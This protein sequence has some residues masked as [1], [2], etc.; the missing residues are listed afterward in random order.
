TAKPL[1]FMSGH[2][3]DIRK[4]AYLPGGERIVTTSFDNTIRIWNVENGEQEGRTME[5][6]G[7]VNGLAV[8]RDGKRILSG[9]YDKRISVWDSVDLTAKPLMFMSGHKD[10]IR[11]LAYLPGGERIVTT[12]FDNTIRIWNVEN[13]EQEGRTMEHKGWVN[14][15][16]VTRD[17]KRILSGGYDKRISVWDVE[18]HKLIEEWQNDTGFIWCIA[19]SP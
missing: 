8:T 3:D 11:K 18:T 12:S 10:D 1:M 5:H 4:L 7:W 2:K 15:L 16:A 14:G 6:K 17:G 9:G 13:G 19:V